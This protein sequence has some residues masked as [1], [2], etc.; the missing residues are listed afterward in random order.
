MD[1]IHSVQGL[2]D[3]LGSK[4]KAKAF[5]FHYHGR[6]DDIPSARA[7][8]ENMECLYI[9]APVD[10][11]GN[12]LDGLQLPAIK[13][14]VIKFWQDEHHTGT[15]PK[16]Q[17]LALLAA[18]GASLKWLEVY[19]PGIRISE[20]LACIQE[21]SHLTNL[22]ARS[23]MGNLVLGDVRKLIAARG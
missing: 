23:D 7:V 17:I 5:V 12:V 14:L 2:T 21:I 18:S 20:L 13:K 6:S 11:I 22:R 1:I 16:N 15:W 8:H 9:R 19:G 3:Y 10:A 4:P